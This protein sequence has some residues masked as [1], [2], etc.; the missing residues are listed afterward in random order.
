[1]VAE[2]AL[3]GLG[4]EWALILKNVILYPKSNI[5]TKCDAIFQKIDVV[6][7]AALAEWAL[8]CRMGSM[9][10]MGSNVPNGL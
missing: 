1:M 2:W 3:N 6:F 5:F 10:R 4:A 9:C 8:K 7:L